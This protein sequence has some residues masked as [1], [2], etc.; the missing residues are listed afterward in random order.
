MIYEAM[1]TIIQ[2]ILRLF[3]L[4]LIRIRGGRIITPWEDDSNFLSLV[5]QMSERSLI[6]NIR[7]YILFQLVKYAT[8]LGEGHG[9]EFGVYRGGSGLLI[10]KVLE[11]A[12]P[13]MI[14]H[15]FD[16][17]TGMPASDPMKDLH[18][19]GDFSDVSFEDVSNFLSR[20]RNIVI[21]K[22]PFEETITQINIE[23]LC[24][25]HVDC[26]I[27]KSVMDCCC[28]I[29]PRIIRGGVIV[30]DDY[31]RKSCPGAKI[32]VDEFFIGK[33]EIPIYLPTGQCF[34]I[35]L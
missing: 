26:D 28:F 6:D 11:K 4:K 22:G 17:F 32:A 1:K 12:K 10:S 21:H 7:L 2:K 14:L 35:K 33:P 18:K 30:F 9:V 24:F 27:Y 15:L 19:E 23:N 3:G 29:Y 25:A 8:N 16:T 20:C 31:G 13:S 5:Y 34:V